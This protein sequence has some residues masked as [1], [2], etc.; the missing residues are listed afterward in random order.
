MPQDEAKKKKKR[1]LMKKK[2]LIEDNNSN[3]LNPK[4]APDTIPTPTAASTKA[5]STP[6][7]KEQK[8][9]CPESP[10]AAVPASGSLARVTDYAAG[11]ASLYLQ[12]GAVG[13]VVGG[14]LVEDSKEYKSGGSFEY[15]KGASFES[16]ASDDAKAISL[17][18]DA[19]AQKEKR[20]L[21]REKRKREEQQRIDWCV[22]TRWFCTVLRG[23]RIKGVCRMKLQKS[24][25]LKKRKI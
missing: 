11:G 14:H 3:N 17:F 9:D 21:E 10:P 2:V 12:D 22:T 7:K 4:L 20:K 1:V 19:K 18:P 15:T 25:F 23:G 24:H 5:K 6:T 8:N 13:G 16:N